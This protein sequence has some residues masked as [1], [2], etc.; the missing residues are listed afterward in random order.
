MLNESQ[1]KDLELIR[2]QSEWSGDLLMFIHRERGKENRHGFLVKDG[3]PKL[4]EGNAF[5]IAY[6]SPRTQL[7][8]IL[9]IEFESFEALLEAGWEID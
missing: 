1:K 6:E 4:Y 7:K 5:D 3:G 8:D 9:A 2:D